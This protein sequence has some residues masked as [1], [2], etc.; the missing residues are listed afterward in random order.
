MSVGM[1]LA[2]PWLALC[3]ADEIFPV[4]HNDTIT[5]R[6]LNGKYGVP[7]THAHLTLAG[8]YDARDIGLRF[9]QEE[10]L[11]DKNGEMRLPNGLANLPFL[12]ILVAGHKLCQAHPKASMFSVDRM[13]RDGLSAPNRCGTFAVE[14]APGVFTVFVNGDN[15]A[16]PVIRTGGTSAVGPSAARAAVPMPGPVDQASAAPTL[17]VRK[18]ILAAASVEAGASINPAKPG[19]KLDA[20]AT[21]GSIDPSSP[22]SHSGAS[23]SAPPESAFQTNLEQPPFSGMGKFYFTTPSTART[24][25]LAP[26]QMVAGRPAPRAIKVPFPA[27]ST[28]SSNKEAATQDS[29]QGSDVASS[30]RRHAR[31]TKKDSTTSPIPPAEPSRARKAAPAPDVDPEAGPPRRHS[32]KA[33]TNPSA[34]PTGTPHSSSKAATAS[35]AGPVSPSDSPSQAATKANRNAAPPSTGKDGAATLPASGKNPTAVPGKEPQ[36]ASVEHPKVASAGGVRSARAK[37]H[38]GTLAN[39]DSDS[40]APKRKPNASAAKPE[41]PASSACQTPPGK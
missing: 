21:S 24:L 1:V 19:S 7:I 14:D 25:L 8:G 22:G 38:A 36:T 4:V 16:P 13:R 18:P 30:P 31:R 35:A 17:E 29:A 6:V 15:G 9:W 39:S 41:Q 10:L 33:R 34:V 26:I 2:F 27:S 23:G 3:Q 28:T 32:R 37:P 40:A 11:T 20:T 12:Q 5:V